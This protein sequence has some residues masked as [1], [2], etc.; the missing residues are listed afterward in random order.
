MKDACFGQQFVD[1]LFVYGAVLTD[2]QRSQVK[3]EDPGLS[4][5]VGKAAGLHDLS[6]NDGMGQRLLDV[7]VIA[8]HWS[9]EFGG[10]YCYFLKKDTQDEHKQ[11]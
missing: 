1:G 11:T 5:Q 6:H 3:P 10:H 8:Q 9:D 7:D 2:V 4:Q